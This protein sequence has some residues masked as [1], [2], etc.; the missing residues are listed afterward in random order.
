MSMH[1]FTARLL[2]AASVTVLLAGCSLIDLGPDYKK[3]EIATPAAWD[4]RAA[5]AGIWPDAGWWRGFGSS[6]LDRLRSE[7]H[8][9]ALQSLMRISYAVFCLKKKLHTHNN[10]RT[11]T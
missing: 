9:S 1:R 2:A 11:N 7:E 8:T 5:G 6:E 3:P 4:S 10:N